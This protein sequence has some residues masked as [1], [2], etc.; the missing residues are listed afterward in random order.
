M[1]DGM[2]KGGGDDKMSMSGKVS[3]GKGGVSAEAKIEGGTNPSI[4]NKCNNTIRFVAVCAV[5]GVLG[6]AFKD[7]IHDIVVKPAGKT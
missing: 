1:N 2:S 4:W 7:T 6:W 5:A 3:A